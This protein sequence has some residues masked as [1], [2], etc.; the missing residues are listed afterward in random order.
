[1]HLLEQYGTEFHIDFG[2]LDCVGEQWHARH[3]S[4]LRSVPDLCS[5]QQGDLSPSGHSWIAEYI[6]Q[7]GIGT[8][9]GIEFVPDPIRFGQ[10]VISLTVHF[11]EPTAP[12]RPFQNCAI[13]G[14]NKIPVVSSATR[15]L[16][17]HSWSLAVAQGV[18]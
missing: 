15:L 1:M 5:Q 4:K 14:G 13:A 16:I 10:G 8:H 3:E 17:E 7:Q 18:R 6:H 9:G 12:L 11:F 2:S